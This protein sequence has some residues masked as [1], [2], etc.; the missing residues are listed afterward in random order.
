VKFRNHRPFYGGEDVKDI[1][2]SQAALEGWQ[3]PSL[4]PYF[5]I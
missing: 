3:L 2:Y 5:T 1:F 4:L